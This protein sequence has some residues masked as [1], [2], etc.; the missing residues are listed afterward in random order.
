MATGSYAIPSCKIVMKL[1]AQLALAGRPC[2]DHAAFDSS[3]LR[4]RRQNPMYRLCDLLSRTKHGIEGQ[5]VF[6]RASEAAF[7][8]KTEKSTP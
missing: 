6:R 3:I 5:Q 8:T 4:E 7:T 1:A 2:R